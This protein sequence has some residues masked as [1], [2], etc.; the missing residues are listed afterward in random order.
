M[1]RRLRIEDL[2]DVAVPEQPALGPDGRVVYVLRTVDVEADRTDRALWITGPDQQPRRLTRGPADTSPAWSPDGTRLAFVRDKQIWLLPADGGEPEAVTELPMGAGAPVW[3]PD[4][5]RIAFAAPVNRTPE[6]G[7]TAPMVTRRVDYK[8]D[9]AGLLRSVRKHLF[10]LDLDS[11]S[12]RQVTDGD[13]HAGDPAWSPD[14]AT[15]AFTAATAPDADLDAR[16]PLYLLDVNDEH[17]RPREVGLADG[18]GGPVVWTPDGDALLVVGMPESPADIAGLLRVPLDGGPVTDLAAPL[19]RNVMPGGPGYPGALPQLTKRGNVLFCVRDRGC[20]HLYAVEA[21]GG[22]P[23][24]IVTG[25]G[26]LVSGLSV[27][28]DTAV[29]VLTTPESFGEVVRV[30]LLTGTQTVLTSHGIAGAELFPRAEREFTISDGTIVHGW[31]MRDPAATGPQPLLLDIHGGPHNAWN[32]AADD[33]HL[34]H[35]QLV[36]DG[37]TVLLLNPRAS[38]GYGREFFTATQSAWGEADADDFLEPV[39]TLVTEGLADPERLA[40]TG[41]S[42]GGYMTCF[43]TARDNPFA[44]AVAGGL[45]ADLTAMAGTSDMGSFLAEYELKARPWTAPD[46]YAAMSPQA[47]VADVTVPTLVLHGEDDLRCPVGQAQQWHTALRERGVPAELV[48]YPGASHLFIVDGP[49]SQ[50]MDYGRRVAEWVRRWTGSRRA[51][52]DAAHWQRRLSA[53]ATSYGVPGATLGILRVGE[54]DERI[55]VAHGVL[56][57]DTGVETTPDSVFQIGSI[58]KVWTATLVMRLVDEGKLDLD[59]PLTDVLPELKLNADGVTMRHLLTHTSGI[60]GDVF[61][62]TGRGDDCVAKYAELLA[63]VAQNHPI[64]ATWS[65]CNA[66]FVLAGLVIERLTGGTWDAAV[67]TGLIEPLGLTRTSTLPEEA[68]KHRTAI[69]HTEGKVAPVWMLPR[70]LGPAGLINSSAPDVLT[71]ARAHLSGG[72]PILSADA[73]A[74]MAAQQVELP[75]KDTLGDSWGLGWIRFGWDG[76]RLIGHDG[77]TIGQQAF[78]RLLPSQGLAITLLTNAENGRDLYQELYTE[79]LAEVAGVA[80]PRFEPVPADG[81]VTPHLGVYERAGMRQEVLLTDDGPIFRMTV[82]GPLAEL[83]PDPVEELPMVAL[84]GD[85]YAVRPPRSRNAIPLVFYRLTTGEQYLHFG[86]RATPKVA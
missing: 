23:R 78:L 52:L 84:G 15:L 8:A 58:S 38:D 31:V 10:V 35:Q 81:D 17:A 80:M 33:I 37:W 63:D 59:A 76:E 46:R 54:P 39:Q 61:T 50:R 19:D 62:D 74:Q 73:A 86:V 7:D 83:V 42:Y 68:L 71:F 60:D 12:A 41:Y 75:E 44:A 65:Y 22:E 30:G 2:R 14:S 53:L 18:V 40:V 21:T 57:V 6:A 47:R 1:A 77:T 79:I 9:G 45:V 28:G 16:A 27:V 72:D 70:S 56:N 4:G 36:A 25:A 51:P 24:P 64:G 29:I 55:T 13:W 85:R 66:G 11:G 26:N 32:A 34:Y 67:R 48:T 5:T 49:P 3:S 43:L 82:T 69:G 20:T